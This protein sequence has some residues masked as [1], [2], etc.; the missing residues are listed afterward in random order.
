MTNIKIK[1]TQAFI[2]LVGRAANVASK[3][4]DTIRSGIMVNAKE[5]KIA[6]RTMNE[7]VSVQV[8]AIDIT[9][10]EGEIAFVVPA[11]LFLDMIKKLP[12]G[13]V[14]LVI[15]DKKM[16]I[17]VGK[18]S[19][20]ISTYA[21]DEFPQAVAYEEGTIFQVE[22]PTFAESLSAVVYA[23]SESEAR[24]ILT[25]VH[26]LSNGKYLTLIAT[27][28][29]RLAANAVPIIA[30]TEE[31]KNV[32]VPKTSVNELVTLIA[33]QKEVEFSISQNQLSLKTEGI[34]FTTRLLDGTFPDVTK[35]IPS[36][37]E[38]EV[39]LHKDELL[40]ALDRSKTALGPKEKI[41]RFSVVEGT[42]STLTIEGKTE[43]TKIF[44]E[45]FVDEAGVG[46]SLKLN[47]HYLMNSLNSMS[48]K[49]VRLQF[50]G[51]TK[52]MLVRPEVEGATQFGLLLPV[53]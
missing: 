48:S 21:V 29:V 50:G 4:P 7:S 9:E 24:P 37:F 6:V 36:E 39:V 38:S 28:S 11:K 31:F 33:D 46:I 5:N 3:K 51:V 26:I 8:D 52:P 13:D 14:E 47:V 27:D 32:V 34:T 43:I 25:G 42:L 18:S 15:E 40:K 19:Y 45:L 44:E 16:D 20:G 22:G 35:L 53:R 23:C 10:T 2:D 30:P 49:K 17:V 12:K 41:A 1:E